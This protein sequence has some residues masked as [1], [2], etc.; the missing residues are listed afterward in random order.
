MLSKTLIKLI[1]QA[2]IPAVSLVAGKILGAL[3]FNKILNIP[4][5]FT[6]FGATYPTVEAYV[7]SNSYSSLVMVIIVFG[8]LL[9]AL[10]RAHM[11]HNTHVSPKTHKKLIDLKLGFL[12]ESTFEI[13]SKVAVWL[14]YSY[15]LTIILGIQ[16]F[17]SLAY[18]WVAI[19]SFLISINMT[20]F[21]VADAEKEMK[22]EEPIEE[23]E[24]LDLE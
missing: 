12:I 1:D 24:D 4:W 8:A 23:R 15:L 22:R 10:V 21:F 18:V 6:G 16:A 7:K 14:S 3:L 13:Y 17:F 11:F 20:W 2:I 19:L 9:W 5:E